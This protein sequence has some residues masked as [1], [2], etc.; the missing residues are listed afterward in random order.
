MHPQLLH[1]PAGASIRMQYRAL[2][3]HPRFTHS[4][5][6]SPECFYARLVV[7]IQQHVCYTWPENGK[8]VKCSTKSK[9]S[10]FCL[11]NEADV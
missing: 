2:K 7:L 9:E 10:I 1:F 4:I 5:L 8:G 6:D 3:F 11:D